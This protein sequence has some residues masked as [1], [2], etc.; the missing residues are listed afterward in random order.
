MI[1]FIRAFSLFL[2]TSVKFVVGVPA[3]YA[4]MQMTFWELWIFSS[5]SG[6]FGVACFV[7]LSDWL[8]KIW[9]N[10]RMKYFPPKVNP[11]PKKVFS[12]RT[13][14]Y[15]KIVRKYGLAGLALLTP[16]LLSIPVGT[17]L[18]RRFFPSRAKVFL[19]ISGSVILWA[20]GISAIL[21]FPSLLNFR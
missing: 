5:V 11:K 1:S 20:V 9:D 21:H 13:R 16:T 19:Y 10:F 6:I 4:T 18:A 14:G 15:V 17:I 7:F 2:L 8:F 12:K 3:A